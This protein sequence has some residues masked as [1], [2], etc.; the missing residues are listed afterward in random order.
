MLRGL[1][2]TYLKKKKSS[3]PLPHPHPVMKRINSLGWDRE[4]TQPFKIVMNFVT[5]KPLPANCGHHSPSGHLAPL[6]CVACL[7]PRPR[8]KIIESCQG[9]GS[10]SNLLS[11]VTVPARAT[12]RWQVADVCTLSGQATYYLLGQPFHY[13]EA[14]IV[15]ELFPFV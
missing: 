10:S 5:Y 7:V 13:G 1:C 14:L 2:K 12:D 4:A 15:E 3:A 8:S 11:A 6:T 9:K